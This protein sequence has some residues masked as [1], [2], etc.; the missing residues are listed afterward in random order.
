MD[1]G[2]VVAERVQDGRG[3]PAGAPTAGQNST[4][5]DDVRQDDAGQDDAGQD[6]AGPGRVGPG[7]APERT[8]QAGMAQPAG[9]DG[10]RDVPGAAFELVTANLEWE[11][12]VGAAEHDPADA[13]VVELARHSGMFRAV[14]RTWTRDPAAG[15][16][17]VLIGYA[18]QAADPARTA[19]VAAARAGGAART[20]VE[21][22]A[23][24]GLSDVHRWLE[25]RCVPLWLAET[26]PWPAPG[27][28]SRPP[29]APSPD[30][31]PDAPL[32]AEVEEDE[33]IDGGR[34]S[35]TQERGWPIR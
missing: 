24:A 23:P 21:V 32:P 16:V 1:H 11:F 12:S 2:A 4:G 8:G 34:H 18:T 14:F 30:P 15:W 27:G 17:R 5:Q 9:L 29:A 10:P 6:D 20:C 33:L 26:Y 19:L 25:R 35:A 22:V 28:S 3:E 13:A 31:D 7:A